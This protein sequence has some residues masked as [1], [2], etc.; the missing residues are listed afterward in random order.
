MKHQKNTHEDKVPIC[1]THM[2]NYCK[3]KSNCWFM[4]ID[5]SKMKDTQ[6]QE[7]S[8]S[9]SLVSENSSICA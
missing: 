3:Y 4:H 6:T 7:E 2:E 5:K 1:K 9:E 8:I